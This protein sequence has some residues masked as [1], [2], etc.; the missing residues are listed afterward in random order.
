[1]SNNTETNYSNIFSKSV[2]HKAIYLKYHPINEISKK[3]EIQHIKL[4]IQSYI[5]KNITNLIHLNRTWLCI[6]IIQDDSKDDI[7]QNNADETNESQDNL[8]SLFTLQNDISEKIESYLKQYDKYIEIV[9]DNKDEYLIDLTSYI[10]NNNDKEN[11]EDEENI[12]LF[13]HKL[14][15]EIE[16]KFNVNI[17]IGKGNNIL[18]A[19]LACLKCF[20]ESTKNKNNESI[21]INDLNDIFEDNDKSDYLITVENNEKSILSFMN[22][23]PLEYLSMRYF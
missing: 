6:K 1:M 3:N 14:K 21:I 2:L 18:L 22:K 19:S 7:S 11:L 23:F 9:N 20:V 4:L 12:K 16:Q 8:M 5:K 15:I 17:F 13:L 10:I